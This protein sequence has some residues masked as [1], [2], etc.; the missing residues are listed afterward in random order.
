VAA[1]DTR[2]T[3]WVAKIFGYA[4][5]RIAND[6]KRKGGTVVVPPEGF[7]VEGT[8]GPLNDGEVE[9]AG[10]WAKALASRMTG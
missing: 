6:V 4:A 5:T 7:S 8:K 1:F 3:S 10:T 9:R 2:I